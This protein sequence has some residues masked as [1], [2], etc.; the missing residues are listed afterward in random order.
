[1]VGCLDSGSLALAEATL[2]VVIDSLAAV[3]GASTIMPRDVGL[4]PI[5]L[6]TSLESHDVSCSASTHVIS[7]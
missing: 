1:M 2:V 6:E 3:V 7:N 4:L 5:E